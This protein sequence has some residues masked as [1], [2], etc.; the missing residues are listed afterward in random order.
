MSMTKK[1]YELVAEEL[2]L[3]LI[4][5]KNHPEQLGYEDRYKAVWEVCYR[6]S[7]AFKDSNPKF[8][9]EKFLKACGIGE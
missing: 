9:R 8:D 7:H 3:D 4:K 6:L 1:D 5:Y 2:R